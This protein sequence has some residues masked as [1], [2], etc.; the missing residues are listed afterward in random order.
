MI[1]QWHA[2]VL[3]SDNNASGNTRGMLPKDRAVTEVGRLTVAAENC[4]YMP[5][6]RAELVALLV[7]AIRRLLFAKV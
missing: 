2:Q 3:F 7:N 1:Y 6:R 4:K 5:V